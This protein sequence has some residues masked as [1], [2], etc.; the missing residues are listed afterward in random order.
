MKLT[1]SGVSIER[2][3]PVMS[4][5]QA[6]MV[7]VRDFASA[8]SPFLTSKIVT[9]LG[10]HRAGSCRKHFSMEVRAAHEGFSLMGG[11]WLR[12]F[13]TM[14]VKTEENVKLEPRVVPDPPCVVCKGGGRVKC[15]RCSG[16]G[17]LNFKEQAML[18]KGEWPQWCWDCRGCGMSYCTRC[19]GTGE[20]RGIIGFHFP[21]NESPNGI[22][23]G[24]QN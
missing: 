4:I 19:L 6:S 23:D 14:K 13:R 17:R 10:F 5:P 12:P 7:Q 2:K 9:G 16:R 15:N 18:P 3:Q 8:S 22:S 20:K 21:D 1:C 24:T 11:V